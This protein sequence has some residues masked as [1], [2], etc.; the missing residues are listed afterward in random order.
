MCKNAN[1]LKYNKKMKY[2]IINFNKHIPC[3]MPRKV[4]LRVPVQQWLFRTCTYANYGA[5][6]G[7]TLVIDSSKGQVY[8]E[9]ARRHWE[10]RRGSRQMGKQQK[11]KH[12]QS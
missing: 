4:S 5:L 12:R 1:L 8:S 3:P 11:K 9:D 10:L 2:F 6:H 7:H